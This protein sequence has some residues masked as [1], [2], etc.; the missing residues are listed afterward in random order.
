VL[1]WALSIHRAQGQSLEFV[2]AS[3]G[4]EIFQAG[5]A[6]VAI[7][8]ACSLEGLSFSKFD[9][10]SFRADSR[11]KRFY[12]EPFAVYAKT[13]FDVAAAKRAAA[14][15]AAPAP[16]RKR[17]RDVTEEMVAQLNTR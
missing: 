7:S 5:Q 2:E 17:V 9:R 4:K 14:D 3:C 1:G 6:Y 15:G 12:S 11:V 8:R 13:V 10:A 16:S